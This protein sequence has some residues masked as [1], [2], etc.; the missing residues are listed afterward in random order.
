MD[1]ARFSE[2]LMG[3][4]DEIWLRHANPWSVWTRVLTPLPLLA[5]AIWSREWIDNWAWV[6]VGAG[7]GLGQPTRFFATRDLRQLVGA[8]RIGRACLVAKPR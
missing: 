1:I 8:R 7:L 4:K 2:R 3:M 6:A 5:L